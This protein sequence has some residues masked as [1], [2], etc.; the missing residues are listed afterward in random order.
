MGIY[1]KN[2]EKVAD[3]IYGFDDRSSDGSSELFLKLGGK[4]VGKNSDIALGWS[5]KSIRQELLNAA[6]ASNHSHL[7]AIDMDELV[8][9][10]HQG[11]LRNEILNLTDQQ[12]LTTD[13]YNLLGNVN[14]YTLQNNGEN[15]R[16]VIATKIR[17]DSSHNFSEEI[18]FSQVPIFEGNHTLHSNSPLIHFQALQLEDFMIKQ[19][20]YMMITLREMAAS[21]RAIN[22]TYNETLRPSGFGKVSEEWR[23]EI[24]EN[25]LFLNVDWRM[26]EI[27]EM[28]VTD[29]KDIF[30]SLDIWKSP[31]MSEFAKTKWGHLPRPMVDNPLRKSVRTFINRSKKWFSN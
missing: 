20:W 14:T 4:L 19:I 12:I 23:N 10:S 22:A 25:M 11:I 29:S 6:Y 8:L 24:L 16:K 31:T 28:L 26:Q 1:F 17:R 5:E 27:E 30:K 18:H 21:A 3:E 13:W 15:F 7:M 9:P 2:L